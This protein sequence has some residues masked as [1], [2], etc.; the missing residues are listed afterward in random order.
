MNKIRKAEREGKLI[1]F[2]DVLSR[3]S[4]K[5]REDIEER[6]RYYMA[7]TEIRKIRNRA[8]L[9]QNELAEKM[10]VKKRVCKYEIESGNQNITLRTL[11]R[12]AMAVGKEFK[13]KFE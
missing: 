1:S 7:R 6:S 3:Y 13:F 10:R 2:E 4:E 5:D 12:V 8:K 11:I 9:T